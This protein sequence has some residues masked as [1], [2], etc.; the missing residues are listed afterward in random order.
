MG[1][2]I[3]GL[4]QYL[5]SF[6]IDMTLT[7]GN[8]PEHWG[9]YVW[10]I[11]QTGSNTPWITSWT[12]WNAGYLSSYN[13]HGSFVSR[14]NGDPEGYPHIAMGA[15]S[16]A[17]GLTSTAGGN[18]GSNAWNW[19]AQNVQGQNLQNDDPQWAFVP[20]VSGGAPIPPPITGGG[21]GGGGNG[22]GNPPPSSSLTIANAASQQ[23]GSVAPGELVSLYQKSL[24]PSL[25]AMSDVT[26]SVNGSAAPLL[27]VGPDQINA[28]TPFAINGQTSASVA[29]AYQ[30]QTVAQ[31]TTPVASVAPAIF[32]ANSTGTGQALV[33]NQDG[34]YNSASNPAAVGSTVTVFATGVGAFNPALADGPVLPS[35]LNP[36]PVPVLNVSLAVG[37]HDLDPKLLTY[38]G[39]SPGAMAGVLQVNFTIPSNVTPGSGLVLGLFVGGARS[40]T[41]VTMAVK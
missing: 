17:Y 39:P 10:P 23:S 18:S 35:E 1:M 20:R 37:G 9:D 24:L 22:G 38:V 14:G 7:P 6:S 4:V 29:V 34:T 33:L 31:A 19:L 15:L 21:G 36:T 5:E 11:A 32:T 28:V 2:P 13:P 30:G 25:A 12:A 26:V 16:W 40:Q 8:N 27:Y 3:G 41:G